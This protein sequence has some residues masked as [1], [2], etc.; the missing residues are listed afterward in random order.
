MKILRP[1]ERI[2]DSHDII[3][4]EPVENVTHFT[5]LGAVFTNNYDDSAEIKRRIG[6]AKSATISLTKIWKNRSISLKTKMRLL[7]T[8]I[9]PIA[10]YGAECWVLKTS[11]EIRIQSFEMWCYR[12]VLRISWTDRIT[13]EEVLRRISCKERLLNTL[14]ERKLAF[15]GHI[16]RTN[17]LEKRLL[18]GMV[19]GNRG[20]GRP[21]TRLS[22]NIK[23][24]SGL[25]MVE[26]ER[27]AQDRHGWRRLVQ[28]ATA[29]QT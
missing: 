17:G 14:N 21:K 9:F 15:I 24:I 22:D 7:T 26:A 25:T 10:S 27:K 13:N 6:I 1:V 23:K 3:N 16:L 18:T 12:R 19:M 20:R 2:D 5:Y 4:N 29:V 11:D 28:R 8:L